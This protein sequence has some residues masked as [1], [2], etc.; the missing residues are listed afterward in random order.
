MCQFFFLLLFF[1]VLVWTDV[2]VKHSEH[3][4]KS[5]KKNAH[6]GEMRETTWEDARYACHYQKADRE[7]V[8]AC[9]LSLVQSP[10]ALASCKVSL[11]G[12]KKKKKKKSS[13]TERAGK[14]AKTT[15]VHSRTIMS[16]VIWTK[17]KRLCE[18]CRLQQVE[19]EETRSSQDDL[20]KFKPSIRTMKKDDLNDYECDRQAGLNMALAWVLQRITPKKENSQWVAVLLEKMLCWCQ[21][22]EENGHIAS[23]C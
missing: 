18:A 17:Q 16:A 7:I 22:S 11:A 23:S 10:F 13:M 8:C 9:P 2:N 1:H 5:Q 12:I 6:N 20:L 21:R 4:G 3:G 19:R 14:K 15:E